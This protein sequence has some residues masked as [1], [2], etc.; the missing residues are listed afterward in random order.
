MRIVRVGAQWKY[1]RG[2]ILFFVGGALDSRRAGRP[3]QG[4]SVALHCALLG[5]LAFQER[6]GPMPTKFLLEFC[7]GSTYISGGGDVRPLQTVREKPVR[8]FQTIG[9]GR[10]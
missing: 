2:R 7:L 5:L 4:S 9:M 6:P 1:A 10:S 3:P 8:I